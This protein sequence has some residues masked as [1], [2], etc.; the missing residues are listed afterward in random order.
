M[1]H[2]GKLTV[3]QQLYVVEEL[4]RYRRP[5]DIVVAVRETFGVEITRQTVHGYH[6]EFNPKL[7][8]RWREAFAEARE[9]FKADRDAH[10]VACLSY[11]LQEISRI[12]LDARSPAFQL[13][14]LEQ[15]AREMGGAYTNRRDIMSW[16]PTDASDDQL[17]RIAA[18]EDP[19]KV[20]SGR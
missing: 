15:A 18:G 7:G 8:N 11:R 3:E 6:P 16:D 12:Y 14:A 4:A 19:R 13:R 2:R 20:L 10:P 1:A 5:S 17:Q 9:R